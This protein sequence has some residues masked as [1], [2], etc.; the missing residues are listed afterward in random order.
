MEKSKYGIFTFYHTLAYCL[1]CFLSAG[2]IFFG[3][4]CNNGNVV[5][6]GLLLI[7]FWIIN[8][9]GLIVPL[10]G[11]I[12]NLIANKF[13]VF[14]LLCIFAACASWFIAAIMVGSVL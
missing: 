3:A 1:V 11:L 2:A 6:V 7:I 12:M 4:G 8:P 5:H 13:K 10:I 9:L 14:F